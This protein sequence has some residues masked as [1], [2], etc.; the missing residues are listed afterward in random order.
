MLV[1]QDEQLAKQLQAIAEQ[2]HRPVEAVLKSLLERYPQMPAAAPVDIDEAVKQVRR[3]AYA[4]AR[5]YWESNGDMAKAH[6]TDAELDEQFWLFDSDG[7]PRLKSEQ[8]SVE[9]AP[10]SLYML[11]Q[12]AERAKID[13]EP[14]PDE[15]DYDAILNTEFADYLLKRDAK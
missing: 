14:T 1:I 7:I 4:K 8:G 10:D 12:A 15:V 9:L 6:L 11:A 13:F 5:I 3:K 2:E